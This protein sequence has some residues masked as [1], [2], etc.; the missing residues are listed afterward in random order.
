MCVYEIWGRGK[1]KKEDTYIPHRQ[2]P[3]VKEEEHAQEQEEAAKGYKPHANFF[4]RSRAKDRFKERWGGENVAI[5]TQR[6]RE[7]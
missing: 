6:T 1:E 7:T 5:K 3:K 4:T 2:K